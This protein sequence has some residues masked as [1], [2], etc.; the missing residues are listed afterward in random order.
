M[1][2]V[3]HL[4]LAVSTVAISNTAYEIIRGGDGMYFHL[5][6]AGVYKITDLH[7][8]TQV[9]SDSAENATLAYFNNSIWYGLTS[10]AYQINSATP[11]FPGAA[12]GTTEATLPQMEV[13]IVVMANSASGLVVVL[14]DTGGVGGAGVFS[15]VYT[16]DGT[17]ATYVGRV[18][19]Q[20]MD[21]VEVDGTVFLLCQTGYGNL[22]G[23]QDHALPIIYSVVGSTIS[24][25]DD[26]RLV[27]PDFQPGAQSATGPSGHLTSDGI[28]LYLFWQGLI[29]RRYRISTSAVACVG[30]P[31]GISPN[32]GTTTISGGFLEGN[33]ADAHV[34]ATQ[35][36]VAPNVNGVMTTSWFDF[37]VPSVRKAF[38]SI[39]FTMNSNVDPTALTVSYQTDVLPG[40]QALAVTTSI[41]GDK[42]IAYLPRDT[43]GSRIQFQITLLWDAAQGPP[44]VANYTISGK[45]TRVWQIGVACR[46]QQATRAAGTEDTT[47]AMQKLANIQNCYDLAAGNCILYI[48]DPTIDQNALDNGRGVA[49][50]VS[51]VGAV[52]QD[53]QR[54]T[55]AGVAPGYR[56]AQDGGAQDMEADVNLILSGSLAPL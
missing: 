3:D 13:A 37:D 34:Y 5:N 43:I 10:P 49:L 45:L 24:V 28:F 26:Y 32:I 29:T 52:L 1:D 15:Y 35:A 42:L 46:R 54:S 9:T 56:Q 55:A 39:E 12:P 18:A 31:T 21:S 11:P 19:A 14:N 30:T 7:A 40:F 16:F 48:P 33:A 25:F 41:G 6:G 50:G 51:M 23:Q 17:T 27:A 47:T 20:A 4:T 8:V 2:L 38:S 22:S 36:L 44:D 53:Y